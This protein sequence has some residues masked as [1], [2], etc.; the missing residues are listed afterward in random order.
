MADSITNTQDIIDSRDVIARIEEL[1]GEFDALADDV[2]ESPDDSDARAALLDWICDGEPEDVDGFVAL[3]LT[4][5]PVSDWLTS[6]EASE[7]VTLESLAEEA[8]GYAE[9]WLY[10]AALIRDT[11]FTEY[12]QELADDIGAVDKGASWPGNCID[13][14][15][16]AELLQQDY[17]I[18]EF[19]GVEYWIR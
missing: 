16:A 8:S 10:G 13:W 15:S 11:Y 4:G 2:K 3:V 19:D 18:V 9:D 17:T 6:Q 7:L 5:E 12:A 14:D 1:R